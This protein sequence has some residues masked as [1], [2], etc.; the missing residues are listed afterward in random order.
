MTEISTRLE[1]RE[2]DGRVVSVTALTKA[3]KGITAC[4]HQVERCVTGNAPALR[5]GVQPLEEGSV[6]AGI[7]ALPPQVVG[8]HIADE[9]A[10]LFRDTV[11]ALETGEDIDE[12]LDADAVVAFARLY[13][14]VE[15]RSGGFRLAAMEVTP[16]FRASANRILSGVEISTGSVS[17]A[18]R[19][20]N[21]TDASRFTLYSSLST[22]GIKCHFPDRL[23]ETVREAVRRH[24]TVSGLLHYNQRSALPEKVEVESLRIHPAE[25]ELPRFEDL[26]GSFSEVAEPAEV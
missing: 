8:V 23:F 15:R 22:T 5:Y 17:G 2:K 13:D 21:A 18:I 7:V 12:R 11:A 4:L 16:Q 9:T 3:M 26:R 19:K 10:A 20:L 1:G 6:I 14:A 24:V 25:T